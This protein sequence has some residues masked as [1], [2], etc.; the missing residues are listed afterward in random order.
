MLTCPHCLFLAFP[1]V[2]IGFPPFPVANVPLPPD[3]RLILYRV[4]STIL[5][6]CINF[7]P[8]Y[9]AK[10]KGFLPSLKNCL[11]C[12]SAASSLIPYILTLIP[13]PHPLSNPL[14]TI[15]YSLNMLPCPHCLFLAFPMVFGGFPPF[16]VANVPLPPDR[17][18]YII[19]CIF[20]YSR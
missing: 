2:F 14:S 13:D 11:K 4:F 12:P 1:K 8:K 20:Q 6:E 18:G 9:A 15:P 10:H 16:P 3:R 7:F 19:P 5:V 17:R